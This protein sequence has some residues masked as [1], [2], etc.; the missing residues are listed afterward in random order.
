MWVGLL[1]P[2]RKTKMVLKSQSLESSNQTVERFA[3]AQ[4]ANF[5]WGPT[6]SLNNFDCLVS[7]RD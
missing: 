2:A 6:N 4:A 3:L 5:N 1:Y 7:V